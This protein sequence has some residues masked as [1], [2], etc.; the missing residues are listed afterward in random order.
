MIRKFILPDRTIILMV[1]PARPDLEADPAIELVKEVDPQGLRT[2]GVLTKIDLMN[3]GTDVGRYLTNQVPADLQLALGYFAVRNRSPAESGRGGLTVRDGFTAEA[4]YFSK[5]AVYGASAMY[6]DRLG[7]PPLTQ[8]LSRVLLDHVRNHMPGILSEVMELYVTTER[9][10]N[11]MGPAVPP[12]E[13][14]RASLVQTTVASFCRDF[15]GA[16]VEKR[17][18]MKV[19]RK[20]KDAFV[21]LQQHV[22][23][24][25]PFDTETYSDEY[26]RE[27]V[28]DCE[29]NHLSF[30]I[31]PIELLEHMLQDPQRRPISKLLVPCLAC[32]A[33]VHDQ[34][35]GM[36]RQ[37]LQSPSLHRFP[38]LV[39]RLREETDGLLSRAHATTQA[40]LEELVAMEENYIYTDDP[41][42]LAELSS[43]IKKLVNKLDAPLLRS[44]LVSY[45]ATIQRSVS[46][47]APKAVMLYMV[48]GVKDHIYMTL[49]ENVS[50]RDTDGL[51]DEPP[52]TDAKRR[53][54]MELLSQLRAAKRV[55]ESLV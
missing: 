6:K 23:D 18:D 26:L 28:R 29:G 42:F 45:Y 11:A 44:I 13:S 55:L 17:A 12:D 15:V 22:R 36:T 49:F 3:A 31:P 5:H 46:N 25:Q 10:L 7:V 1:C 54:D 43:A 24:V 34:L 21:G 41:A 14:S 40:K 48:K 53:A 20:I 35:R 9:N 19:G 32:L 30:P 2:V 47:A 39:A 27:A 50:R 37:L 4:E 52:E 51:L 33:E 8:F 38:K 16:L